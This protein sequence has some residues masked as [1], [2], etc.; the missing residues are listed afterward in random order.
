MF[1]ALPST[2]VMQERF[3]ARDASFNGR[4]LTG[5][6]TTGIYCLPSCPARKPLPSNVKFFRSEEEARQEGLRAC[7]RCR[8][9]HYY[10]AHDPGLELSESL[11]DRMRQDPSE[12]AGVQALADVAGT[13]ASRINEL[14]RRHYHSTPAALLR[15][16]RI[17]LAA[18]QIVDTEFSILDIALASGFE[19]LSAFHDSFR[20]EMAMTPGAYRALK[21]PGMFKLALPA[22]YRAT[23]TLRMW[24]RDPESL[25]EAVRGNTILKGI[26]GPGGAGVLELRI[27]PREAVCIPHGAL[28]A[29]GTGPF[30]H[31]IAMR[32]LGLRA[33]PS[34]FERRVA[35]DPA[36]ARLVEGRRG[37]RIP[38]TSNVYEAVLWAI[39]G[40]QVNLPFAFRLR[41]AVVELTGEPAGD[42]L[43]AHP[44]PER[45]AALDYDDLTRRQFSRS[46]AA[47]TIDIAREI[48]AR[49]LDVESFATQSATRVRRALLSSRGIGE[50]SANYVMMR[51]CGFAD[52]VP[53]GDTGLT[54]GLQQFFSL[55]E[56]P[57]AHG[58]AKLME[59][60]APHRSLATFHLWMLKGDPA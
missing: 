19:S 8:P 5:V 26:A 16:T 12:V 30:L 4:F 23:N 48:A 6:I 34:P 43:Y 25:L 46:K 21:A 51:G 40:Q 14:F 28:T 32:I 52:C 59:R 49:R 58:T 42:G 36:L 31:Q 9:D 35:A 15:R 13:S 39:A 7:R 53:A 24:G 29:G 2:D 60:F 1:P 38:Q 27:E 41:R 18:R 37:L 57:D 33:D 56:R 45:V 20:K 3:R 10:R 44:T 22:S 50:W 54:S 47:Y 11:V 17:E 55:Q